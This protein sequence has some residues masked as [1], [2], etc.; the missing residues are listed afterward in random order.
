MSNYRKKERLFQMIEINEALPDSIDLQFHMCG[1]TYP[2]R[3]YSINRLASR[4]CCIEFVRSGAGQVCYGDNH[5]SPTAGDTYMLLPDVDHIYQSDRR[6]PWEKIWVNLSGGYLRQMADAFGISS[7]YHFQGLDTSDL[8]IKLQY[9]AEHP[10]QPD[11]AEKCLSIVT[12]LFYRMSHAVSKHKPLSQT[13]VQRMLAYIEQHKTDPIRLDQLAEICKKSPS[14]A[15]RLFRAETGIPPY[16]YFLNRKLDLACQLL[17]ETGMSVRDI[18][19][20]LSFED[21]FYFSGLFRKKIGVS[22]T[23]YRKQTSI[24]VNT[25]N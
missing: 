13:P 12:Q 5:F 7:C 22:P 2:N 18:A 1:T 24:T 14:Q 6:D 4:I 20:Y 21:E 19:S 11:R 25:S 15:E 23:Q 17:R 10:D 8:L 3:N 9:Y 16:R